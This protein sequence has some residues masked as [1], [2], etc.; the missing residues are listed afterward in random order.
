MNAMSISLLWDVSNLCE[1]CHGLIKIYT[2]FYKRQTCNYISTV[3][4]AIEVYG[5]EHI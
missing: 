4:N 5:N 2:E 1:Q 3:D